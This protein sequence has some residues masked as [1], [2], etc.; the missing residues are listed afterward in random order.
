MKSS[1]LGDTECKEDNGVNYFKPKFD[2]LPQPILVNHLEKCREN[3]DYRATANEG[4]TTDESN[5]HKS[6]N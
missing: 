4:E 5:V 6:K 3:N 2:S 1:P